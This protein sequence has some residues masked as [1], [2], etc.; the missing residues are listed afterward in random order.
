MRSKVKVSEYGGFTKV[1][2][3]ELYPHLIFGGSTMG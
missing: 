3:S 1:K 2:F